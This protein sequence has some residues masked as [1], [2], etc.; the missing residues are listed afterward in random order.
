MYEARERLAA[1]HAAHRDCIERMMNKKSQFKKANVH[2]QDQLCHKVEYI[3]KLESVLR[4]ELENVDSQIA[5]RKRLLIV[6]FYLNS[7]L[8]QLR[9]EVPNMKDKLDLAAQNHIL[10]RDRMK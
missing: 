6:L 8:T 7:V 4:R 3:E 9:V 10:L 5:E 1:E 2:S